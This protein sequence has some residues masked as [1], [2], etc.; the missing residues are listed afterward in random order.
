MMY[1]LVSLLFAAALGA[2]AIGLAYR[3]S[4]FQQSYVSFSAS[5]KVLNRFIITYPLTYL[6]LLIIFG[7]ENTGPNTEHHIPS[8][9]V[10]ITGHAILSVMATVLSI[11]LAKKHRAN[12]IFVVANSLATLMYFTALS[13]LLLLWIISIKHNP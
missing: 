3:C 5:H 4:P 1:W 7:D 6:I 13:I 12:M 11:Y 2:T 9:L 10:F 8:A